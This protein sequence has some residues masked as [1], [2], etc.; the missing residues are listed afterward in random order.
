MKRIPE[1]TNEIKKIAA[2]DYSIVINNSDKTDELG[3]LIDAINL[4]ITNVRDKLAEKKKAGAGIL[5][6]EHNYSRLMANVPAMIYLLRVRPDG[7]YSFPFVSSAS[8]ELFGLEPDEITRDPACLARLV[9]PGDV[10]R[11]WES[12]YRASET[13]QPWREELRYIVNGK[14]RWYDCYSRPESQDNGDILWYGSILEITAKKEAELELLRMQY[15]IDQAPDVI[16]RVGPAGELIYCNHAASRSLG[17]TREELLSMTLFDIQPERR[18]EDWQEHWRHTREAKGYKIESFLKTRDGNMIPVD[19][20]ARFVS[21][22]GVEHITAIARD[23]SERKRAEKELEMFRFC[24]D[25]APDAIQWIDKNGGFPYVNEQACSSL[26][27][28][29][30]E[31]MRLHV[32]DIDPFYN[33]NRLKKDWAKYRKSKFTTLHLESLH[34][35]KDGVTFPVEI[36]AK[37]LWI[38]D[39]ELHVAFA[40]DI[41]ERK[42][43]EKSLK[44]TQFAIDNASVACFWLFGDGMIFYVNDQAC[45]SLGYTREELMMMSVIDINPNYTAESWPVIWQKLKDAGMLRFETSHRR[46]DGSVFPVEV[47]CSYMAYEGTEYSFAFVG[48]MTEVKKAEEEKAQLQSQLLQSQKM[49]S[50][51]RLAGG[52]AHE[53]NNMLSVILGYTDLIKS[54]LSIGAPMFRDLLEIEKAAN[55]SKETTSQLLAFSRKQMIRPRTMD[56]N[57]RIKDTQTTLSRLIGEDIELSV[58]PDEN[59][60]LIKFD[61]SQID[62]ILVNLAVNARDAMPKGGKFSITTQNIELDENFCRVN[63]GATPGPYVLLEVSDTGVGMD[64]ETLSH[65]FEPFYTTKGVGKGTGL[66][67]ATVYG[68]VRQNGGYAIVQSAAK[69]GTTFKIFLPRFMEGEEPS[70]EIR[71]APLQTGTGTV[72]LVE[73]EDMVRTLTAEMLKAIGYAPLVAGSP[74]EAISICQRK[75]TVIDLMITDVVMPEMSGDQLR[76]KIQSMQPGIKVLF[77]S[78]YTSN[79]IAKHGVLE[80]G[81][82]FIHKPFSMKDLARKIGDV[83]G[84]A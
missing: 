63:P 84:A 77:M 67:L 18:K 50:V 52:V 62:Q 5:D 14:V 21:F 39:A 38:G 57:A 37:H 48:D 19:I 59:L 43:F 41:T 10:E 11:L 13:L 56:L 75:D 29:R 49:E 27:Y 66:G 22:G 20:G 65:I 42:Q 1:L 55:R 69:R 74:Q 82:H 17:Y 31:M 61:G 72:L 3:E 16:Y 68:I 83:M 8:R 35:R 30:E 51:G 9:H 73:D 54:Q 60:G 53:F 33:K 78:G 58:Y 4:L 45:R 47:I 81:A 26:G 80:K 36:S 28:T 2:G 44:F 25:N 40:R 32:W 76:E 46:K 24:L 23:I 7:T 6:S 71:E 12:V 15:A 70:P 64:E 34:K 79:I